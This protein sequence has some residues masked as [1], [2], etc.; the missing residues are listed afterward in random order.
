[1]TPSDQSSTDPH[2]NA[3]SGFSDPFSEPR[4][5]PAAW[6]LSALMA[7]AH[8]SRNGHSTQPSSPVDGS[9][10]GIEIQL[11]E[12]KPNT[13]RPDPFPEPKTYPVNWDFSQ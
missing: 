9:S 11:E 10:P 8:P 1:M 12:N 7:P 4:T 3:G 13:W 2:F 6:D 5:M